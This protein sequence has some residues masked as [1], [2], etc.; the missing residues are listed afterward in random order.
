MSTLAA[1]LQSAG[2]F[3]PGIGYVISPLATLPVVI[4]SR[5][6]IRYGVMCYGLTT[7]LLLLIQPA[8]IIIFTMTTGWLGLGIGMAMHWFNRKITI[9]LFSGGCL[10]AGILLILWGLHF[11]VLGPQVPVRFDYRVMILVMGFS[12]IYSW[13]W[14]TFSLFMVHRI[15][16]LWSQG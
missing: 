5:L 6:S 11:P 9:V 15:R 10:A 2:G 4:S 16:Q 12:F 7:V 3:F 8:E 1:L 14:V 13:I